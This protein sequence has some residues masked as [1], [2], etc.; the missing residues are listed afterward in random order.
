MELFLESAFFIPAV[1]AGKARR[2]GLSTDSSYRFERG[3]D[4]GN[5]R[6]AIEYATTLIQQIC[7]GSAG[8]I[9]EVAGEMPAR[10]AVKLRMTRLVSV[11]GL[12]LIHI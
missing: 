11:L 9:T 10:H 5:T 12:S 8:E 4:F 7:G 6:N 1:I 2:I 3:V